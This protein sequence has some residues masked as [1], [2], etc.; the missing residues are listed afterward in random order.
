MYCT[1]IDQ[2]VQEKHRLYGPLVRVR[3]DESAQMIIC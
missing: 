1:G 3:V 2:S